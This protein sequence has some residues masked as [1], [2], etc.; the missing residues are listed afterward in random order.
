MPPL[1]IYWEPSRHLEARIRDFPVIL[2]F[3]ILQAV[4]DPEPE[5]ARLDNRAQLGLEVIGRS[6][7]LAVECSAT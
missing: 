6:T 1:A 7:R 5:C 3:T 2:L 4:C